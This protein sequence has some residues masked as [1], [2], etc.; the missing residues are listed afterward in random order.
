MRRY[1]VPLVLLLMAVVVTAMQLSLG[2]VKLPLSLLGNTEPPAATSPVQRLAAVPQ[3]MQPSAPADIPAAP[4]AQKPRSDFDVARID[5]GGT[6]VFAGRTAPKQ[7]VTVLADGKPVGTVR[8]DDNGE[9][10]LVVDGPLPRSPSL[11]V[12]AASE[13]PSPPP[14]RI[15]AAEP[16]RVEPDA[17]TPGTRNAEAVGREIIGRLERMVA[18]ARAAETASPPFADTPP[19]GAPGGPVSSD[20]GDGPDVVAPLRGSPANANAP[21]GAPEAVGSPAVASATA[22]LPAMPGASPTPERRTR[23]QPTDPRLTAADPA[24]GMAVA[25]LPQAEASAAADRG[26]QLG[27]PIPIMFNYREASFTDEGRRAAELLLEYVR[28]KKLRSLRLSGHAD[29]RGTVDLN[30]EL[31]RDR[32][33]AVARFMRAGGYDGTLDMI[34][35]GKSQPFMGVD[36]SKYPQDVLY[37]LDRR[38][39]L[40]AGR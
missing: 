31:S 40:A 16:P 27:T 37:Q 12:V 24:P 18:Q 28:L 1:L 10:T 32:L 38:V 22:A 39:E 17:T 25:G 8:A 9:W 11:S 36:R 35:R 6:S 23:Q 14:A 5:P 33:E 26:A 21:D 4:D 20:A 13:P 15:A 34:P 30:L 2:I 19:S 7:W 3:A 29:E